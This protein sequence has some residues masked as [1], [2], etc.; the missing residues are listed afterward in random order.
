MNVLRFLIFL[1]LF[2]CSQS[3]LLTDFYFPENEQFNSK[4]PTPE[5]VIG[6]QVGEFHISHDKL[7][8]Y[9]QALAQSSDRIKIEN[10]GLTFEGRPLI[11]LTITSIENHKNIDQIR[12]NHINAT[13]EDYDYDLKNRPVVVYQGFS[14]HGN[15]ASGSNAAVLLAY[16]LAA[17]ESK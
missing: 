1:P 10:R 9:M 6:H 14:I 13:N 16:S 12:Q 17:N 7:V 5:S 4:I 3:N 15:E 11:L 2:V 8:Q